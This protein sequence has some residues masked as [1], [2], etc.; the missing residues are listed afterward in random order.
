VRV[1]DKLPSGRERVLDRVPRRIYHN[2]K[3]CAHIHE[4]YLSAIAGS[5]PIYSQELG[6]FMAHLLGNTGARGAMPAVDGA[7]C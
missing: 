1:R 2:H 5:D 4:R 3:G 6:A 7:R